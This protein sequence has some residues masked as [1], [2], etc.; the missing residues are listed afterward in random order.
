MGAGL[1]RP[2]APHSTGNPTEITMTPEDG[3]MGRAT[4]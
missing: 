3:T 1:L 4:P 2:A